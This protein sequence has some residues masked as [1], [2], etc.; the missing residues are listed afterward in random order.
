MRLIPTTATKAAAIKAEAKLLKRSNNL[1]HSAALDLAAKNHGYLHWHH[2]TVCLN[3]KSPETPTES[4][5]P[6][7]APSAKELINAAMSGDLATVKRAIAS[8]T[9]LNYMDDSD[10]WTPLRAAAIRGHA[11]VCR[12]LI[13]AHVDV[14]TQSRRGLY[15]PLMS[16]A[17]ARSRE[18][19]EMLIHAGADVTLKDDTQWTALSWAVHKGDVPIT[20]MLIQAGSDLS[21]RDHRGRTLTQIADIEYHPDLKE[22]AALLAGGAA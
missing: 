8:G 22:I 16:A 4:A 12:A 6:I 18:I 17:L 11:D 5:P 15:T 14:N 13:E 3:T 19:C 21:I 7:P 1:S 2:V 10:G 9:D 20:R